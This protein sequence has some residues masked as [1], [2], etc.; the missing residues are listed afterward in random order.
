MHDRVSMENTSSLGQPTDRVRAHSAEAFNRR[1]DMM[2][3]ASVA[4]AKRS[5][6]DAIVRRVA[7]LDRE[8]DIDRA[9]MLNVAFAGGTFLALGVRRSLKSSRFGGRKNPFLRGVAAQL[10]FLALHAIVG[11]CPPAMLF[12]R[13]GFRTK[14]EIASERAQLVSALEGS[15]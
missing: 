8:W 12:R 1:V 9:L 5:G 6:H 14:N 4:S 10:A 13:L 15:P 2:T 7:E 11:W 3:E